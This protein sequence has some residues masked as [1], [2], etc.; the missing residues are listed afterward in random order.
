MAIVR[1]SLTICH[2]R[3][4]LAF[5]AGTAAGRVGLAVRAG[6]TRRLAS[7]RAASPRYR[8]F[9]LCLARSGGR[10]LLPLPAPFRAGET[11]EKP[12]KQFNFISKLRAWLF[13]YAHTRRWRREM[14]RR[15]GQ[16]RRD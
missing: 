3:Y 6:R 16:R 13:G 12:M 4:P 7:Y 5:A 10:L 1:I 11:G 14:L 9:G 2:G 8:G 15:L